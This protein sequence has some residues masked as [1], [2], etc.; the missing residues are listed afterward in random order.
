MSRLECTLQKL[1]FTVLTLSFKMALFSSV[2]ILFI[3]ESV[4]SPASSAA[5]A[6]IQSS[7][8]YNSSDLYRIYNYN[9]AAGPAF[10]SQNE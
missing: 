10:R 7:R 5:A 8:D 3:F 6:T 9:P 2:L 1:Q 4:I